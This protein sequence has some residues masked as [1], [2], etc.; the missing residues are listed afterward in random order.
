MPIYRASDLAC[1]TNKTSQYSNPVLLFFRLRNQGFTCHRHV[2]HA[3]LLHSPTIYT[4]P[5]LD[6]PLNSWSQNAVS[7]QM[8]PWRG[9]YTLMLS[10]PT[11]SK[12]RNGLACRLNDHT[13]GVELHASTMALKLRLGANRNPA[14]YPGKPL[15]VVL[16]T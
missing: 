4:L 5:T 12:D 14:Q 1:M 10:V 9:P 8:S 7:T 16:C 13:H 3:V 2:S 11:G 15:L 6:I